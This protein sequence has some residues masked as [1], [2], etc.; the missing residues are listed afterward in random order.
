EILTSAPSQQDYPDWDAVVLYELVNV[1]ID[2]DGISSR[3]V[4]R[5]QKL[6]TEWACRNLSDERPG[7]DS[8]RQ[9]LVIHT[10]RT[11]N[12][13]GSVV[14]TPPYGFNEVTPDG[15]SRC[16]DFLSLRETVIS[17]VG[18]ERGS[19]L[20]LDYEIRDLTPLPLPAGGLEFLQGEWPILTKEV[21]VTAPPGLFTALMQGEGFAV[22][23]STEQRNGREIHRWRIHNVPGLP[24]A[25]DP[26][27][28]GD[29]LPHVTFSN[30]ASWSD[31][32]RQL[33][34]Y[35]RTELPP[36]LQTWL[37][38]TGPEFSDTVKDLSV[39]DTIDRISR[40][41][42]S[43]IRTARVPEPWGRPPRDPYTVFTSGFGTAWEKAALA[44]S[45]LHGL[46]LEPELGFFSRWESF[47]PGVPGLFAFD[48]LRVVVSV[49]NEHFWLA[50]GQASVIAGQCD[51]VGRTAFFLEDSLNEYRKFTVP[52]PA[53]TS[54]LS[55]DIRPDDTNGFTAEIDFVATAQFR[56][57]DG[58]HDPDA[59]ASD[60]LATVFSDGELQAVQVL[61]LAPH[62][63][64]LRITASGTSLG[65]TPQ[66]LVVLDL[67]G[68]PHDLISLLPASFRSGDRQRTAPLYLD[69][70]LHQELHCHFTLPAG[71]QLDTVLPQYE[72]ESV[73][74]KFSQTC[75]VDD[76]AVRCDRVLTVND[77]V[78]A[79]AAYADFREMITTA[80][81][82]A[83]RRLVFRKE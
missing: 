20:E 76:Q 21:R 64:H 58:R 79:P 81:Q 44:W 1:T 42:G 47:A 35:C 82:P 78:I 74:G 66:E 16:A 57:A 39:T 24:P 72:L 38:Q 26:G 80:A 54:I 17:H 7:W 15:V 9:E 37:D 51:L 2:G 30:G 12:Q 3:R 36:E 83:N 75:Q 25:R 68:P 32:A 70:A 46:G 49:N 31:L 8:E 13:D 23:E 55:L 77:G 61:D 56:R 5:F 52:K 34:T 53:G 48:R 67:P 45:L 4:H 19:I 60:L 43:R 27:H 10:C 73:A 29:Y 6:F 14:D 50:P 71:W 69:G 41:I 59:I 63:L 62:R 28:R 18:V 65:V 11:H 40:L 22:N 33:K